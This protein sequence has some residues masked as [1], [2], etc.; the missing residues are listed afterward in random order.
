MHQNATG[1][2]SILFTARQAFPVPD[3]GRK[4]KLL[5][6][7]KVG[8]PLKVFVSREFSAA[9]WKLGSI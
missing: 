2:L 5:T 8:I 1:N 3:A 6:A 9:M 4:E 7:G